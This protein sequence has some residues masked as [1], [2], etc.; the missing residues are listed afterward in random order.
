MTSVSFSLCFCSLS[1]S[2]SVDA[3]NGGTAKGVGLTDGARKR[4]EYSNYSSQFESSEMLQQPRTFAPIKSHILKSS[5]NDYFSQAEQHFVYCIRSLKCVCVYVCVSVCVCACVCVPGIV[6]Q[7]QQQQP[8]GLQRNA[9]EVNHNDAFY[10]PSSPKGDLQ[11]GQ[12]RKSTP[13]KSSSDS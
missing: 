1:S 4:R 3:V 6:Q 11:T 8:L 7:Q 9:F 10:L 5:I 13:K 12:A 2:D